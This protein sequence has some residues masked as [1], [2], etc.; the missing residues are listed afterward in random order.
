MLIL[1]T[2][3][4]I[5][6]HSLRSEFSQLTW[7]F[8]FVLIIV[9]EWIFISVVVYETAYYDTYEAYYHEK[10]TFLSITLTELCYFGLSFDYLP[11]YYWDQG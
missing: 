3:T 5:C 7:L 10:K 4:L 8:E 11:H 2:L 9:N 6:W 1:L